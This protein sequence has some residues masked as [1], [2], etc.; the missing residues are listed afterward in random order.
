M[1]FRDFIYRVRRILCKFQCHRRFH[2]LRWCLYNIM[3]TSLCSGSFSCMGPVT[4]KKNFYNWPT[5]MNLQYNFLSI[6]NY[7]GEFIL[8]LYNLNEEIRSGFLGFSRQKGK[9]IMVLQYT[10]VFSFY[11]GGFACFHDTLHLR[12]SQSGTKLKKKSPPELN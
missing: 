3:S 4:L 1:S 8:Q 10:C 12:S 2:L 6:R 11:D 5:S 9:Q 7:R